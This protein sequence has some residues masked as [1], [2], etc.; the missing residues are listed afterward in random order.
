MAYVWEQRNDNDWLDR[1]PKIDDSSF[2]TVNEANYTEKT[3]QAFHR[4]KI[5]FFDALF[6]YEQLC[7]YSTAMSRTPTKAVLV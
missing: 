5:D 4:D 7:T 1:A 2:S 6:N 3:S